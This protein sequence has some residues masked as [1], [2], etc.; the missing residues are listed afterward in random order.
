MHTSLSPSHN[1]PLF[2]IIGGMGPLASTQF[3]H[4]IYKYCS[5]K[6]A[7]EQDYPRI[8]M[9]SDPIIPDR[10][11]ALK[12]SKP[13]L[14]IT[15]FEEKIEGLLTLGAKEIM[16]ACITAHLYLDKLSD[17]ARQHIVSIPQLLYG[18]LNESPGKNLILSSMA[19][20]ENRVVNHPNS[21]YP[22]LEDI[23]LVQDYIFKI[24]L[25]QDKS[26]FHDFIQ[27]IN[28][29]ADKYHAESLIFACT[30]LH[31]VN[32]F[33]QDSGITVPY[34][35]VDPLEIVADYIIGHPGES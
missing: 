25:T 24:K 15:S 32:A 28:Q 12:E 9:I 4:S 21:I 10:T 18:K 27:L 1:K 34:R 35:V 14:V 6:F 22:S 19:T 30:E 3:L 5:N 31:L 33:I 13:D 2:G 8:I 16:I 11:K 29:L 20:Y 23:H 7:F 17:K 26:I